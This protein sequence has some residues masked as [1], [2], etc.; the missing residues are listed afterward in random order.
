VKLHPDRLRNPYS[1]KKPS[2]V[3]LDSMSDLFHELIPDDFIAQVFAV[4]K[5]TPRHTYQVLTKRAER[6]ASWSGPWAEN[7]WMGVSVEDDKN[8]DRI[9]S[10]KSC[11][12]LT[13]FVSYE[14]A[15]G[16]LGDVDLSGIDWLI[17]GG[18]SGRNHRRLDMA[19]A[20]HARDLCVKHDVAFFFKQD[21]G[22]RTEMRPWI[23]EEGGAKFKWHQYPGNREEPTRV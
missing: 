19:W 20:R 17:C 13:K 3:F 15:L 11:Q 16:P 18:E 23:V 7:I 5:D 10:L 8:A 9:D 21:S 14:P 6:A 2:K 12:A 1:W 4:M 22:P